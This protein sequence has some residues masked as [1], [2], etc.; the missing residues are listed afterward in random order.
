[1]EPVHPELLPRGFSYEVHKTVTA[2][3]VYLWAGLTGE[4][5]PAQSDTAFGQQTAVRQGV[6]QAAYL[7]GLIV[8]TASR[9]AARIPPPGAILATLNVHFTAPVLVGT[10]ISITVTVSEWDATAS[11]YWLDIRATRADGTP[12]VIGKAGLRPHTMMLAVA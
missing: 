4:W 11:L 6:T 2:S 5:Y 7:T 1:M 8:A 9:L 12:A 3:D 10:T